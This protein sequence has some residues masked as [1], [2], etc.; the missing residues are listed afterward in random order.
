MRDLLLGLYRFLTHKKSS[1]I[2]YNILHICNIANFI[3]TPR[4]KIC[5]L[6]ST[7]VHFLQG[8]SH[9]TGEAYWWFCWTEYFRITF[10]FNWKFVFT[11]S[12]F[13]KLCLSEF[14]SALDFSQEEDFPQSTLLQYSMVL[15]SQEATPLRSTICTANGKW[16]SSSRVQ[17][18][19]RTAP[20][21][22]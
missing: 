19:E 17:R 21:E 12:F 8:Q 20:V 13:K 18:L 14:A 7:F 3:N 10:I 2:L 1:N 9:D 11:S 16:G 22:F 6:V 4:Q 5:T 15:E